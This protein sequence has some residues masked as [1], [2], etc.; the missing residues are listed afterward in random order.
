MAMHRTV[1]D[2]TA[3]ASL[4]ERVVSEARRW[5]GTP[6]QHQASCIGAGADCLGLIRGVWRALYGCEPETVAAYTPDWAE[7]TGD[8]VM[9]T[10]AA[11]HCAPVA[12][13]DMRAGDL[14]VF[15][16]RRTAVAKHLGILAGAPGAASFIHAYSGR[17]VAESALG[18][19]WHRRIA[20][21]FRFPDPY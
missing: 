14:L 10:R 17:A 2:M 8:E 9:L 6:Y 12:M 3:P 18:P 13:P 15:R 1:S 16:M 7:V 19:A 20:G 5:I 11:A 4:A 21:V